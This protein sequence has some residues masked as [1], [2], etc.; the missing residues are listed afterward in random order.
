MCFLFFLQTPARKLESYASTGHA[1]SPATIVVGRAHRQK[2]VHPTGAAPRLVI[3]MAVLK[4]DMKMDE[5]LTGKYLFCIQTNAKSHPCLS[6]LNLL[7]LHIVFSG[8][9]EM[10]ITPVTKKKR[11]VI[12]ESST[13]KTPAGDLGTSVVEPSVLNTPEELGNVTATIT[14]LFCF[15]LH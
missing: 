13:V 6:M 10:Y 2:V 15:I 5:D 14:L 1:N 4:K 3:N 7:V 12:N 9:A 11:S 8:I